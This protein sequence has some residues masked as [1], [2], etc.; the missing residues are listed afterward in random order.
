MKIQEN[1]ENAKLAYE[2]WGI[3]TD[4]VLEVL[5][6]IPISVHCWQGDDIRGFET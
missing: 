6:A 1:Y 2:K 5:K 3:N 4:E